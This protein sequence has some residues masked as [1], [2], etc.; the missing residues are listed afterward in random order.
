MYRALGV[1]GIV[2]GLGLMSWA[3]PS[4]KHPP[5]II[6]KLNQRANFEGI[7][8]VRATLDDA[9]EKL[10]KLYDVS[11]EINE[12]AFK[13]DGLMEV[14]RTE[15]AQPTPIPEM[16]NARLSQVL[17]KILWRV[18]VPSGAAFSV[19]GEYIE[20]TT[21]TFQSQA[22]WGDYG[23]PHLPLVNLVLDKRPLE[24]AVRELADLT[25]FNIT[26]DPRAGGNVKTPV[27]ARFFNTPLDTALRLL[28]DMADL[29]SV[30]IDNVL[31]VT[32]KDNA[33]ALEE[34]LEKEKAN[35]KNR[36]PGPEGL[37]IGTWR[38]GSG[39]D[40]VLPLG[41]GVG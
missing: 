41:G 6:Q 40:P 19:R 38:Q 16:K 15:I 26:V 14:G 34:R 17:R 33:V 22:I 30:H 3:A 25:D 10:S 27:S 8:N 35:D 20:I 4:S 9:L 21:G 11:F 32:T 37:K 31:Y 24:D 23:G 28:T 5:S 1:V 13:T 7:S 12:Q 2:V 29:R 36:E 18:P 39:C